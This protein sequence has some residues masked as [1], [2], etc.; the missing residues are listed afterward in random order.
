MSDTIEKIFVEA[1]GK[2]NEIKDYIDFM[3][4][5]IQ[6]SNSRIVK[7]NREAYLIGGY[8]ET[9]GN[10]NS[11]LPIK[12]NERLLNEA[13]KISDK[14]IEIIEN[15]K[16]KNIII[17]KNK[18]KTKNIDVEKSKSEIEKAFERENMFFNSILLNIIITFEATI[19]KIFLYYINHYPEAYLSDENI[20][21]AKI[22]ELSSINEIKK[23]IT[24]EQVSKIMHKGI[25]E[26]FDKLSNK[27][28]IKIK[29]EDN[30]LDE[31]YEV[32]YRRNILV[33]NELIVNKEYLNNIPKSLKKPKEGAYLKINMQY[34]QNAILLA[35]K[36]IINLLYNI[37]AKEEKTKIMIEEMDAYAFY[38]M[39]E[40]EW[41]FSSYIYK[42]LM[43]DYRNNEQ[44][45]LYAKINYWQSTKRMGKMDLIKNE[46][47]S[48]DVSAC[49]KI[50]KL[51]KEVLLEKNKE[52]VETLEAIYNKQDG[53]TQFE[54]E[55]WPL[56]LEFRKTKEFKNF[57]EKHIEDFLERG[58]H[59]EDLSDEEILNVLY[60]KN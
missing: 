60:T 6:S 25:Q 29:F 28:K 4:K 3:D 42:I 1:I 57:K 34:I 19:G 31:F 58:K 27:H 51:A 41:K 52:A 11:K 30:T 17:Y 2:F 40:K 23:I 56:F 24:E 9:L 43:N 50:F 33:H 12:E 16:E 53:I 55:E 46:I 38:C 37:E 26:W 10:K 47:E 18:I 54:I 8:L 14:Y 35:K 22:M 13:K 39:L 5:Y 48:L 45:K 44:E 59:I 49:D 21:Y 32:Y 36:I 7:A 15:N 20:N